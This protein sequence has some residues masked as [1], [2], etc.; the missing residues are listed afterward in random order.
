MSDNYLSMGYALEIKGIL[1]LL[2]CV[3]HKKALVKGV[4][5]NGLVKKITNSLARAGRAR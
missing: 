2:R 3:L 5:C 1:A 4:I